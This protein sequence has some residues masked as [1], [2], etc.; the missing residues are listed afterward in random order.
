M[1]A[2][3]KPVNLKRIVEA[4][5]HL[6]ENTKLNIDSMAD[7]L[8]THSKRAQDI[9]YEITRAGF[10]TQLQSNYI[11]NGAGRAFLEGIYENDFER[12]S[13]ILEEHHPFFLEL[14]Q[15]FQSQ[16][17]SK[18]GYTIKE[19]TTRLSTSD[20]RFNSMSISVLLEWGERLGVI[21]RNLYTKTDLGST[22]YYTITREPFN[23]DVHHRVLYQLYLKF[24]QNSPT[25]NPKPIEIS[26]LREYTCESMRI[27][28]T[29]FDAE[30]RNIIHDF[31]DRITF[32][33]TLETINANITPLAVQT[34]RINAHE[35][36]YAKQ[37]VV[38]REIPFELGG[39]YFNLIDIH[40]SL[41]S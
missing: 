20:L 18:P 17:I 10:A 14:L 3:L 2:N 15:P 23:S 4:L 39:A 30:L 31:P 8:G 26:R 1:S 32:H 11:I 27:P 7:L 41:D 38:E 5:E 33:S 35:R 34:L 24:A 36:I 16:Q 12:I 22:R 9:L 28:R 25:A 21:Q 40:Q 13:S 6:Q 19:L 29:K 37:Y